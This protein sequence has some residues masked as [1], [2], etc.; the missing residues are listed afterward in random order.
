MLCENIP[1]HL[2]LSLLVSALVQVNHVLAGS[3]LLIPSIHL[4]TQLIPLIKWQEFTE[5]F[6]FIFL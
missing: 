6:L 2:H 5:E 4:L 1:D 3:D